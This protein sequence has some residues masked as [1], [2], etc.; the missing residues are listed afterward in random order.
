MI[1]S[2]EN[3]R[4]LLTSRKTQILIYFDLNSSSSSFNFLFAFVLLACC[5]AASHILRPFSD[6]ELFLGVALHL[7][8]SY[9]ML[10]EVSSFT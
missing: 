8:I 7:E 6:T 10:R 1:D 5:K 3:E 4:I 2:A 9:V